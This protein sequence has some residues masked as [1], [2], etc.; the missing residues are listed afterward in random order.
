MIDTPLNGQQRCAPELNDRA[1][2]ASLGTICKF[3]CNKGK[4]L[5]ATIYDM[6]HS[7]CRKE[8]DLSQLTNYD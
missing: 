3:S 5:L 1:R 7:K 2:T 4:I 8:N 6:Q